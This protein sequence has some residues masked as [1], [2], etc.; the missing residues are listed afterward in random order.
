MGPTSSAPLP[1]RASAGKA[2][3]EVTCG[4]RATN[5]PARRDRREWLEDETPFVELRMGD[6]E[7]AS[8]EVAAAPQ[9]DIEIQHSGSPPPVPAAAEIALDALEAREH[10]GG[11]MFAF[12]QGNGVREVAARRAVRL[13]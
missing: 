13:A 10:L 12:D 11:V 8:S 4:Q 1:V 5:P 9:G 7:P 6:C 3:G 2:V